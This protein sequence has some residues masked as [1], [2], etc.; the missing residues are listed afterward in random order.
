MEYINTAPIFSHFEQQHFGRPWTP[1]CS[2]L[3]L[4]CSNDSQ[5][6][7]AAYE[8]ESEFQSIKV[9]L[10]LGRLFKLHPMFDDA[11]A[12][13]LVRSFL[14]GENVYLVLVAEKIKEWN[15][16]IYD[17]LLAAIERIWVAESSHAVDV[18]SSLPSELTASALARLKQ[19]VRFVS[20][21]PGYHALLEHPATRVVLDT[22]P[23]GGCLTSHDAM[24]EGVP[25]V[26][27]PMT[28]LSGRFSL[29]M[30]HQMNGG[31]ALVASTVEEYIDI[32]LRLVR[33]DEFYR[34]QAHG[35][36]SGYSNALHQNHLVAQE[37]ASFIVRLFR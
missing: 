22:F 23:Y 29:A 25:L 11:A 5:E 33:D 10:V 24:S 31:K 17:R 6:V 8:A 35:V 15:A 21:S 9:C 4:A 1:L 12:E 36:K 3:G 28:H 37:W 26:T 30:F 14:L 27:M 19:R 16:A 7:T 32:T 18:G 2:L 20:Y 34:Q 13:I